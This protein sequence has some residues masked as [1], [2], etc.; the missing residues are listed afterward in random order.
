MKIKVIVAHPGKKA[1]IEEITP[2][3]DTLEQIVGGELE[4]HTPVMDDVVVACDKHGKQKYK[5]PNRWLFGSLSYPFLLEGHDIDMFA[6]TIVIF[7][8]RKGRIMVDSLTESEI[9]LYMD[10]YGEPDFE[11]SWSERA[12]QSDTVE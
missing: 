8:H 2:D 1:V 5:V 6:G 7:G 10:I 3:Y 12:G 11:C 4:F 9:D